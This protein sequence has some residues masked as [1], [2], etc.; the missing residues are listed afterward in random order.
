MPTPFAADLILENGNMWTAGQRRTSR[1]VSVAIRADRIIAIGNSDDLDALS[2]SGTERVDLSGKMIIPGFCDAH[3][4]LEKYARSLDMVD[5]ETARIDIALERLSER[6]SSLP[7]GE[8]LLGHGWRL[9]QWGRFGTRAELDAVSQGH[10]A[11]ITSK[12]LHAAWA[13]SAA[14]QLAGISSD[15]ADPEGGTLMRDVQGACTGIL[16]ENALPLVAGCIPAP[17]HQRLATKLMRAQEQL[18]QYGITAVHDFDRTSCFRALQ[19]LHTSR[20][21]QMRVLKQVHWADLDA[22]IQAGL[23]SGF[24]DEWLRIGQSKFFADGALGPHTAF[25]LEPYEGTDDCGMATID[26][27]DLY[28]RM[29][30]SVENKLAI[31]VH[32][33]GDAANRMVLTLFERLAALG[34]PAPPLPH[35]IEHLQLIHPDDL[36]RIKRKDLVISMQPYHAISDMEIAQEHWGDTRCAT[37][38]AW[39]S[40]LEEDAI[41]VFGSDAPVEIPSPQL[42]IH[43]AVTRRKHHGE[44][45][46]DGWIPSQRISRVEALTAYTATPASAA[47]TAAIQGQLKPGYLADIQVY[48]IHLLECEIDHMLTA[49]PVGLLVGG[50]WVLRQF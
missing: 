49:N 24:G 38:Y 5:C 27:E 21:L 50:K 34:L 43:A 41:L 36:P 48:D 17:S 29:K 3:I 18:H 46:Q 11:Y 33:L 25:M 28:Q 20:Q 37:A 45:G 13:N 12:S 9:D 16:L 19:D 4:H 40:V 7:P 2:E 30:R 15:S 22:S 14:L 8:W 39:R 23:Q 47:G 44:P 35:R 26:P 31:S 1:R 42:G 32:A 6:A 10:P